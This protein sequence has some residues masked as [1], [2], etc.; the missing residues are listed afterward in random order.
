M[1]KPYY[2]CLS[3]YYLCCNN[4]G[5]AVQAFV[6]HH[7]LSLSSLAFTTSSSID[8]ILLKSK[9]S[10]EDQP[11]NNADLGT[12]T[13]DNT[14]HELSRRTMMDKGAKILSAP[15]LLNSNLFSNEAQANV[16]TLPEYKE[17]N[18]V[19]QGLTVDVA[20]SV[21]QNAMID[22]LRDGLQFKLLRQ[23]KVGSVTET[24]SGSKYTMYD[25]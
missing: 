3:L 5:T 13:T 23:R 12:G 19:L 2:Y 10:N 24:V 7:H 1:Y 14:R 20:D 17:T 6:S 21:Q 15:L 25:V 16:G 8:N 22:F 18:A 4:S 9:R 11:E